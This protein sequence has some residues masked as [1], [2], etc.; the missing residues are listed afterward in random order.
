MLNSSDLLRALP[1][2]PR[3]SV[4][5]FRRTDSSKNHHIYPP[6]DMLTSTWCKP[7]AAHRFVSFHIRARNRASR[8][9]VSFY[10]DT[11]ASRK[12]DQRLQRLP[13]REPFGQRHRLAAIQCISK[14]A[15][16]HL[17]SPLLVSSDSIYTIGER[18]ASQDHY[19]T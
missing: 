6:L 11:F 3:S 17:P 9:S 2:E 18:I 8:C 13:L 5:A 12:T 10:A 15:G 4:R 16:I 19:S 7:L 1:K 14:E